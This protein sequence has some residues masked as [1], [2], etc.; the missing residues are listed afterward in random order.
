LSEVNAGVPA[1]VECVYTVKCTVPVGAGDPATPLTVAVPVN[2]CPNVIGVLDTDV[3]IRGVAA[4]TVV[5]PCP[6]PFAPGPPPPTRLIE[7]NANSP[8]CSPGVVASASMSG[9][10]TT[11]AVNEIVHVGDVPEP[12]CGPSVIVDEGS[13]S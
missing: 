7:A 10:F 12:F 8:V 5:S 13:N 11:V 9:A 4:I 6:P 1:H 3:A 2:D